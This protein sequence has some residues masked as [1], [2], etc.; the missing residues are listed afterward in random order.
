MPTQSG[1]TGSHHNIIAH[2]NQDSYTPV[3]GSQQNNK[4]KLLANRRT[5][6]DLSTGVLKRSVNNKLTASKDY[7]LKV[8]E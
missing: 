1:V 7:S 2:Q 8:D 5:L 6:R 3:I 4:L